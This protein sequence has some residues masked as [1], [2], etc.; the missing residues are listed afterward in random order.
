LQNIVNPPNLRCFGTNM[1]ENHVLN[2]KSRIFFI[3]GYDE[4]VRLFK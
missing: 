3:K 1:L 2:W 4:I